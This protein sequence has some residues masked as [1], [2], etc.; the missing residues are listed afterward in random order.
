MN[1]LISGVLTGFCFMFDTA[2]SPKKVSDKLRGIGVADK[3]IVSPDIDF[4]IKAS[5]VS[6]P[7]LCC[8]SIMTKPNLLNATESFASICVPKTIEISPCFSLLIVASLS[9]K[10]DVNKALDTCEKY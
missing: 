2:R 7:N 6:T 8:S 5:L 10:D 3:Y 4:L 1:D 9:F